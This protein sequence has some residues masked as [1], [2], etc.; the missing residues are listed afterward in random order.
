M[1]TTGSGTSVRRRAEA[2]AAA[3]S[4]AHC[5]ALMQQRHPPPRHLIRPVVFLPHTQSISVVFPAGK[6]EQRGEAVG[7]WS[8]C[9]SVQ[10]STTTTSVPH[11][12]SLAC[13]AAAHQ[14][15]QRARLRRNVDALHEDH[16]RDGCD[17]PHPSR[18][19]GAA[20][21]PTAPKQCALAPGS[22]GR[23][24]SP[25]PLALSSC[26]LPAISLSLLSLT[27]PGAVPWEGSLT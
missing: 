2:T 18:K 13:T 5:L 14:R 11:R 9:A 7:G 15:G 8:I 1:P 25:S 24:Q 10:V 12:A 26:S 27:T 21:L 4:A 16:S 6:E 3:S 17:G 20:E 23:R 22:T 19:H